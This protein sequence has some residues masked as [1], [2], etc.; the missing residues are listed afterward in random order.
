M[1]SFATATRLSTRL[2]SRR[3]AQDAATRGF[4]TSAAS[5]AA[6]NFTMPALSPTMTEGNIASWKL[7]EG[8]S[9]SAGDVLLE[10]ETDKATMDVEAQDDGILFKIMQGDGSKNVQVGSRIGVVAESGDD[11]STLEIPADEKPAQKEAKKEEP[12]PQQASQGGAPEKQ[13]SG[14]KKTGQKAPPQKYPLYPSVEHLIKE[15]KLDESV[16][17]EIMP[18]GPAGRLLK[19]DVLAYLGSVSSSRPEEIKARFDH[20]SHLDLSNIKIAA[21]KEAP[22]KAEK[23]AAPEAP[24]PEDLVVSL[25]ILLKSVIQAQKKVEDTFDT[26]IPLSVFVER[27]AEIAN[28]NLP[29]PA[30]YKPTADEL[31]NDVLGLSKVGKKGSRGHYNP[32]IT[33]VPSPSFTGVAPKPKSKVDIIDFLAG[34]AKPTPKAPK[35]S[36]P[37]NVNGSF[38]SLSLTVPKSEELRAKAFLQKVKAVLEANPGSLVL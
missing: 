28:D 26:F 5:F 30:N 6:Q 2:A 27:A 16:V 19:G 29:L 7:K 13:A 24:I 10:I 37:L 34:P 22:K 1:A 38:S 17:S 33:A 3:V 32:Q 18:T 12:S 8:D 14:P 9:F 36:S 31:F 4:R 23:A 35:T 15:H 11:L 25:P 21:P 20:N